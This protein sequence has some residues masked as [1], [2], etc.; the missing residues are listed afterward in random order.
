[1]KGGVAR[2][3]WNLGPP[4]HSCQWQGKT[5]MVVLDPLELHLYRKLCYS[6]FLGQKNDNSGRK[7]AE[8]IKR[9]LT[10]KHQNDHY[11]KNKLMPINNRE[12]VRLKKR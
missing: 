12:N 4:L 9:Q 7:L 1:M 8:N 10:E 5:K 3:T 11:H 6:V 2:N